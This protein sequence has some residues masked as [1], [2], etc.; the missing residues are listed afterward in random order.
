[1]CTYV[2]TYF[3]FAFLFREVTIFLCVYHCI[4]I[5]IICPLT[6]PKNIKIIQAYI[7]SMAGYDKLKNINVWKFGEQNQCM[8]TLFNNKKKLQ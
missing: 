4:F 8:L 2:L 5:H 6:P 1:M 3:L 7:L